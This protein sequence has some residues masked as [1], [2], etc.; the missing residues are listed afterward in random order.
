M[1]K[2][3]KAQVDELLVRASHQLRVQKVHKIHP[4]MK[5]QMYVAEK[6]R[7]TKRRQFQVRLNRA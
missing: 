3:A 7:T 6:I 5:V 2:S 4:A 1:S